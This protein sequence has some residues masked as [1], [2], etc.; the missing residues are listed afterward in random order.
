[1]GMKAAIITS[2]PCL[3]SFGGKLGFTVFPFNDLNGNDCTLSGSS[4][5]FVTSE[6]LKLL[7]FQGGKTLE[8]G[9]FDLLFVHIGAGERVN[10]GEGNAITHDVEYVN[11]LIDH[12]MHI[13]QPGSEVGSR[14]HLSLV[15]SY[16]FVTEVDT[17][18]L[19]VLVPKDEMNPDL[20]MLFPRQSYTVKGEKLRNDVR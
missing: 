7:G 1:M 15:M 11:T 6:L 10:S 18:N 19:S 13:A 20:S 16:G 14:L 9:Q 2:N 5:D 12:I 4:I 17:T 3:K 8:T